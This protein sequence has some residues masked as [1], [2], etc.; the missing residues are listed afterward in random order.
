[1]SAVGL[2]I[3]LTVPAAFQKLTFDL[4][5]PWLVGT[6]KRAVA[7]PCFKAFLSISIGRTGYFTLHSELLMYLPAQVCARAQLLLAPIR[8]IQARIMTLMLRG[9]A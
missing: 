6:A 4:P 9:Q 2:Q 1:M 5:V 3:N 7:K 8:W